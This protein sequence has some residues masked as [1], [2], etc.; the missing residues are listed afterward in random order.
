MHPLLRILLLVALPVLAAAAPLTID[1][2][3]PVPPPGP[4]PYGPGTT[5]DP[6]GHTFTA[7]S[8][9]F[10]LDG[11]P[12]IPVAGEFHYTRVPR[13]EWRDELL[14][15]K[16]GGIDVVSTYV[17]WI[18]QEQ[19]PG[20]FD[21]S[22]GRSLREFLLLCKELGLK[23]VVRMGPWCHGEVRNGGFPDWVQHSGAKLRSTD[24]AFLKLVEPLYAEEAKQMQGLLWKDGGPVIGVQVDNECNNAPYL[25]ALKQMAID[26]GVDVPYY[27]ITGWQ[28]TVPAS[29]FLPL[30]GGY[31]DG[32]W[33]D[34]PTRYRREF[35]FTNIRASNN[36]GAQGNDQYTANS[37]VIS[38]FPYAC[39][40]IGPGMMSSYAKRVTIDPNVVTAMALTKLGC[41][42]NMPGYYM[43]HGGINP[44]AEP[45]A[46]GAAP[47]SLQET[48]PNF[49]PLKDY[50]FQTAIGACGEVREQFHLLL[51]QHLFLQDFGPK[52][53]RM[54]AFLPDQKPGGINDFQTLRWDARSDGT[55]GFLFFS[56]AQPAI[57]L[58]DHQN[59]QFQLKTA[60]GTTLIPAKPVIIPS[61]SY[62]IWPFNLDCDGV[63]VRYATA[64][65]VCRIDDGKG[66][67]AYFFAAI[68]GI[69]PRMAL[70]TH[71]QKIAALNGAAQSGDEITPTDAGS[72]A[73]VEVITA[74]GRSVSFVILT[75]EESL[76]IARVP[77]AARQRLVVSNATV[78]GDAGSVRLQADDAK[79]LA[80]SFYPPD[81]GLFPAPAAAKGVAAPAGPE[82]WLFTHYLPPVPPQGAPLKFTATQVQ[83]A[84]PVTLS[85]TLEAAWDSAAIYKLTIPPAAAGRHVILHFHYSGDAARL[86]A[87]DRL[88][89]DQFSNGS[90][91]F[92]IALWRIPVRDWPLLRLKVLPR[93][94]N[95]Q[96]VTSGGIG[97]AGVDITS[98]DQ[99]EVSLA[100]R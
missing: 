19:N 81:P 63:T 64:Q 43:Y 68:D 12:W 11:K 73:G 53:A 60:N 56:N 31:A 100:P 6:Q 67:V 94:S 71:G 87:G 80:I 76:H 74:G 84:G 93:A 3:T 48:H 89:D 95:A 1:L 20:Q 92:S 99:I 47:I 17:F 40:E 25:R 39:A 65:P 16:A 72:G 78:I 51:L 58:P 86:Y 26:D 37:E 96:E 46:S 83:A 61:G 35:F 23:A 41:G 14:K 97:L 70:D 77:L 49:M 55:S 32:F 44:D 13:A 2:T 4:S 98:S 29:E 52:L 90:V 7:D 82:D 69:M 33:A 45:D 24:P 88:I 18:H 28:I 85:G 54:P 62:G 21:W 9:S 57:P 66:R 10:F 79:D 42:N 75:P 30:F 5:T 91:P 59:V 34:A 38:H 36:M 50:D 22:G 8:R 27:A 15:M